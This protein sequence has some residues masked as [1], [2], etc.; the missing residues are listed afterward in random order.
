L[1][2]DKGLSPGLQR[3]AQ[4]NRIDLSMEAIVAREPW[5]QL[6]T[7]EEIKEAKKR[8]DAASRMTIP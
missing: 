6:F 4:E 7:D 8:L 5:N 1:K 2:A 3:L